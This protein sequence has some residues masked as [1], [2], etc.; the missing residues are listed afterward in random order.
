MKKSSFFKSL[1]F[2][3]LVGVVIGILAGLALDANDEIIGYQF[4]NLGKMMEA[5]GKGAT[6]NEAYEKFLSTYGRF[7][8]AAKVIDPRK[9]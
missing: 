3:L 7:N 1:P 5:I 9:E 6:P 8:E 2:K 4:V